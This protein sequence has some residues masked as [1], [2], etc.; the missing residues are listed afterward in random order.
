[1]VCTR[2]GIVGVDHTKQSTGFPQVTGEDWLPDIWQLRNHALTV[3][4]GQVAIVHLVSP[5]LV[6]RTNDL[7]ARSSV[8]RRGVEKAL[9]QWIALIETQPPRTET[10][11]APAGDDPQPIAAEC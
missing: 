11:Y 8:R 9:E 5:E 4:V 3:A 1:M 7:L 10:C 2:C 6:K